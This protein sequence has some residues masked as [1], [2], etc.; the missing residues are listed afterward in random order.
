MATL[1]YLVLDF[2]SASAAANP[3]AIT[4]PEEAIKFFTAPKEEKKMKKL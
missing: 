4:D 1:V 3:E 2:E